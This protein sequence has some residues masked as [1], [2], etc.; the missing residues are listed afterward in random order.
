MSQMFISNHEEWNEFLDNLLFNTVQEYKKTKEYE[1]LQKQY[2]EI[3]A[4]SLETEMFCKQGLKD[5]TWPLGTLGVI[6]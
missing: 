2:D 6:A 4:D 1:Y 5:C 3:V